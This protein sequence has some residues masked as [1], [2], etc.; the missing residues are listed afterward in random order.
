MPIPAAQTGTVIPDPVWRFAAA[1]L[2]TLLAET[3]AA[4]LLGVRDKLDYLLIAGANLITNPIVNVIT[5]V[6]RLYAAAILIPAVLAMEGLTVY[7]EYALYCRSLGFRQIPLL[8]FSLILNV[9]SFALGILWSL[10]L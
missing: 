7:A 5:A 9:I 2:L 1:L 10:L 3:A 8:R 6:L 4:G